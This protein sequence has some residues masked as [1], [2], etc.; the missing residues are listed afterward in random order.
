MVFTY[1]LCARRVSS[2]VLSMR[3]QLTINVTGNHYNATCMNICRGLSSSRPC[4]WPRPTSLRN[5]QH[6]LV[7]SRS[8]PLWITASRQIYRGR[9]S[10]WQLGSLPWRK[11]C[12]DTIIASL[13]QTPKTWMVSIRDNIISGP[14]LGH[15]SAR[16]WSCTK[17]AVFFNGSGARPSTMKRTPASGSGWGGGTSFSLP[18]RLFWSRPVDGS[19]FCFRNQRRLVPWGV[20]SDICPAY[21]RIGFC[22]D[23]KA[24]PEGKTAPTNE[25]GDTTVT[26]SCRVESLLRSEWL[27]VSARGHTCACWELAVVVRNR[28]E[29]CFASVIRLELI[30]WDGRLARLGMW[31]L[32]KTES[33]RVEWTHHGMWAIRAKIS[34]TGARTCS[35]DY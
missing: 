10:A 9:H 5:V 30:I 6:P 4:T 3:P 15:G 8:V 22:D 29:T 28:S 21:K 2:Y 1:E 19:L 18:C 26:T 35:E 34:T 12:R 24:V 32:L 23:T 20:L 17:D 33:D 31:V 7:S 27:P 11:R 14:G 13:R 25:G 16:V